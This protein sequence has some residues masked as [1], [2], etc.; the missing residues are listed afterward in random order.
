MYELIPLYL[1]L[2]N[3]GFLS[4]KSYLEQL[5]RACRSR[6]VMF[7]LESCLTRTSDACPEGDPGAL[8]E[9]TQRE[10]REIA[11]SWATKGLIVEGLCR[12]VRVS[13]TLLAALPPP[14]QPPRGP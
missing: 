5:Y 13:Q 6:E 9:N 11:Y 2:F 10:N 12:A 14:P 8:P 3:R 7:V 4:I 1:R